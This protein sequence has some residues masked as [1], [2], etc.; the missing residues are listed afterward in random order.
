MRAEQRLVV[1]IRRV[2]N[3]SRK[4]GDLVNGSS[5]PTD[6]NKSAVLEVAKYMSKSTQLLEFGDELP[7][8]HRQMAGIRLYGV[9]KGLRQYIK[10]GDITA[11]E[12]LDDDA[13]LEDA[14]VPDA[15][16]IARWFEDTS[17]YLITD[18]A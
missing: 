16:A 15:R 3:D 1:D 2:K 5:T 9:S 18:L 7:E 11:A 17:E 10:A 13:G 4:N 12:L 6:A 8:F 14:R